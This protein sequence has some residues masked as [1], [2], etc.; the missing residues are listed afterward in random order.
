[1]VLLQIR[2]RCIGCIT[3]Q[4]RL[5][6][7][8]AATHSQLVAVLL[9]SSSS[10]SSSSPLRAGRHVKVDDGPN[11]LQGRGARQINN[12]AVEQFERNLEVQQG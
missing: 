2:S 8:V 3:R 9:S 7:Q 11:A 1:M 10:S 12:L 4:G 5:V 6:L